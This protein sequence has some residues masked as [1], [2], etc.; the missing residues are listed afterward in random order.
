MVL[1]TAAAAGFGCGAPPGYPPV[2]RIAASPPSILVN[3]AFMTVVTLDGRTSADPIDDP[4][5][6]RP[7]AYRWTI[8]GDEY[9]VDEGSLT[10]PVLKLRFIGETPAT[11]T[12]TVT[13]ED[14]SSSTARR[15]LQLTIP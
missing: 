7:L 6:T 14:G 5:G 12:L 4:D 11:I 15:Q 8:G 1:A 3:D 2:A 9:R 10:T 13:D